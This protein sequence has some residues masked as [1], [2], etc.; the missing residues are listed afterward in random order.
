MNEPT[1]KPS[2]EAIQ[3][4]MDSLGWW[5]Q[6]FEFPNGLRTGNG[7]EPGY[8]AKARWNFIAPH[9]PS[10]LAGKTVLDLGGNAGKPL[11]R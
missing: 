3:Q 11:Q 6:H 9:V 5:Y 1:S 2:L 8:D 7:Q 4:E 10:D